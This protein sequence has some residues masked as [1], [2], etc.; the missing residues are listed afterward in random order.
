MMPP[1]WPPAPLHALQEEEE[2]ESALAA[3]LMAWY[4][5]GYHT[6]FYVVRRGGKWDGRRGKERVSPPDP[7]TLLCLRASRK[8]GQRLPSPP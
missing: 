1:P 8:A 5:S 7:P 6:G 2:E 4:M 3:M